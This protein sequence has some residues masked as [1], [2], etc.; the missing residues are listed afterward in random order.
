M[1]MTKNQRRLARKATFPCVA[2]LMMTLAMA[3]AGVGQTA[4]APQ[5][6][7]SP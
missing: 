6:V 4:P 5:Q 1:K 3:M 7:S 2:I